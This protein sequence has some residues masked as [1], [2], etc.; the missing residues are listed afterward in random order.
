M[1]ECNQHMAARRVIVHG[2][3]W[4]VV[5]AVAHLVISALPESY[6]KTTHTLPDLLKQLSRQPGTT[7]ILCL[8]PR[9]HIFLFYALKQALL[10][11]PVMVM[12]DDLMFSDQLVLKVFGDI[13]VIPHEKSSGTQQNGWLRNE[14]PGQLKGALVDFLSSPDKIAVFSEVP[15]I[16][17]NPERLMNY[18]SVL[19]FRETLAHG[20]TPA[21]RRLLEEIYK[22]RGK[23]SVLSRR[24]K[25]KE[26][27]I[28]QEKNRLLVKNLGMRCRLREQ[29]YGTRFCMDIQKTAFM[30]PTEAEYLYSTEDPPVTRANIHRCHT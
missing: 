2:D 1:T 16:F 22:G 12:S 20:V 13:P 17:N 27:R 10:L 8:R 25:T 7:L 19:M 26:K 28:W 3:C 30:T 15:L 14:T 6:C 23:L 5:V 11:H 29:L 18:M 21:Q 4:P 9:E 24:L